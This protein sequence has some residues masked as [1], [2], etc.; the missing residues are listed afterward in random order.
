MR[1]HFWHQN[2]AATQIPAKAVSIRLYKLIPEG[3][4]CAGL[5]IDCRKC[6]KIVQHI[7]GQSSER[8]YSIIVSSDNSCKNTNKRIC[9]VGFWQ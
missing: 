3:D 2:Y 6:I 4:V 1:L 5:F 7:L 9:L 8:V